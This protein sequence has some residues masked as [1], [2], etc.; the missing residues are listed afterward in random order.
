MA[1]S[2]FDSTAWYRLS[3]DNTGEN[4]TISLGYSSD[5]PAALN[6]TQAG[7]FSSEN[8]QIFFQSGLYFIRNYD[9]GADWQLGVTD[10]D[11]SIPRMLPSSGL[12]GME[13]NISQWQDG[14][15]KFTNELLGNVLLFGVGADSTVPAMNANGR[16][17]HWTVDINVSAGQISN[18][19][20]LSAFPS[21]EVTFLD[22]VFPFFHSSLGGQS[23][24]LHLT[25]K[26]FAVANLM[27]WLGQTATST[28]S[29][30]SATRS[31]TSA[32]STSSRTSSPTSNPANTANTAQDVSHSLS[33][34]AIAGIAV[35]GVA[36][37]IGLIILFFLIRLSRRRRAEKKVPI[38]ESV[39]TPH[40]SGSKLGFIAAHPPPSSE[41][42]PP[43]EQWT[44]VTR[45]E[46]PDNQDPPD[47]RA[48]MYGDSPLISRP[49]SRDSAAR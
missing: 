45:S 48:E 16:G 30:S 42:H 20:L 23:C 1:T 18:A 7:S 34:G 11:R 27:F 21:L 6:M 26:H 32:S 46:L 31:A 12:L 33:G 2:F 10:N 40:S 15:W 4:K 19:E 36:V 17:A 13:W 3:N 22:P 37:V 14:T 41:Q 8:W 25:L 5:T 49:K 9:Y 38:A 39:N 29:S 43:S 28:S 44:A 47:Y 35:G 24:C